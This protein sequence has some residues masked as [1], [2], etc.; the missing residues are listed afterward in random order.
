MKRAV[1]SVLL[2]ALAACGQEPPPPPAPPPLPPAIPPPVIEKDPAPQAQDEFIALPAPE[3]PE[4]LRWD[5]SPGKRHVYEVA[6]TLTQAIDRAK[7]DVHTVTRERSRSRGV[8]EFAAGPSNTATVYIKIETQ[9]AVVNEQPVP[10]EKL[11]EFKPTLLKCKVKE[12]GTAEEVQK[13]SGQADAQFFFDALL[14]LAPGE[15]KVKDGTVRTRLT[16]YFKVERYDCA[17][18]ETEFSFAPE[19]PSMKTLL[20]GKTTGYFALRERRFVRVKLEARLSSRAR[21]QGEKGAWIVNS[22]DTDTLFT[23]K[24]LEK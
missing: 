9:E 15:K 1:V 13:L 24:L 17:R 6:Q 21:T 23:L 20:E 7:G 19:S 10:K 16:G 18:L 4:P 14:P 5:F 2:L 22:L 11:E 3:T 12:D 8:F